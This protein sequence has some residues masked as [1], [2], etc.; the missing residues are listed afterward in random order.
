MKPA[1]HRN[2]LNK[3]LLFLFEGGKGEVLILATFIP[4]SYLWQLLYH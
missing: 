2:V 1:K 3:L 4:M